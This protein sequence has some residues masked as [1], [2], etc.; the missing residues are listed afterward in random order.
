MTATRLD[1][2]NPA[3]L[4]WSFEQL[5]LGFLRGLRVEGLEQMRVTLKIEYKEQ[6]V[7]HNLDLYKNVS[8]DKLASHP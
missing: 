6:A 8:L 5:N 2:T 1:V 4:T 7:R 3:F